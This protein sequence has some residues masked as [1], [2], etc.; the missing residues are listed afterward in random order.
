VTEK[1]NEK[2]RKTLL[3]A[4]RPVLAYV[5]GAGI[6]DDREGPLLRP[7]TPDASRL[8]RR[9]LDRK[10]PVAYGLWTGFVGMTGVDLVRLRSDDIINII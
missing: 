8:I 5:E 3:D 4:A 10:T 9:H 6:K 2:R 1:R 7:L